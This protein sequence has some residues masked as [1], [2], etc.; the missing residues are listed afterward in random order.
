[1]ASNI[2]NVAGN[3][4]DTLVQTTSQLRIGIYDVGSNAAQDS[5]YLTVSI[6]GDLA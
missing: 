3:D 4:N 2:N 6:H 5:S 1:M